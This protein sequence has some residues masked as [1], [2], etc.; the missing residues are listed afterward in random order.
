MCMNKTFFLKERKLNDVD[1]IHI[2]I[3]IIKNFLQLTNF[4]IEWCVV[5]FIKT[6]SVWFLKCWPKNTNHKAEW[7]SIVVKR[8]WK[9]KNITLDSSS[10][11]S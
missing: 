10:F 11:R 7:T 2:K 9:I 3:P 8:N 1:I 6:F 4:Q 5:F